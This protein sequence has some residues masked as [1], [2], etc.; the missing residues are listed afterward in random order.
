MSSVDVSRS[1]EGLHLPETI[2]QVHEKI[3]SER[4]LRG[5]ARHYGASFESYSCH[6]LAGR[7]GYQDLL[8][9]LSTEG[10][11]GSSIMSYIERSK[12]ILRP[13][14]IKFMQDNEVHFQP[15]VTEADKK[16]SKEFDW[17]MF[18]SHETSYLL[19]D[20]FDGS[21]IETPALMHLR[22]VAELFYPVVDYSPEVAKSADEL[23]EA[24]VCY[25]MATS[26]YFTFASPVFFNAGHKLPNLC[27]CFL[28]SAEDS[29]TGIMGAMYKAALV[30]KATGGV[31][32]NISSLRHSRI[33]HNGMSRGVMPML[34]VYDRLIRYVDQSG[35]RNGASTVFI[36]AH[37]IDLMAVIRSTLKNADS[38]NRLDALNTAI[39]FPDLFWERLK[40]DGQWTLFC[41]AIFPGLNESYGATYR[42][43]YLK[44]ETMPLDARDA[45][46]RV[47]LTA[48]EVC[49]TLADSQIMS[50]MPYVLHKDSINSCSNQ[51]NLKSPNPLHHRIIQSSNLCLEIMEQTDNEEVACC[52][53]GQLSLKAFVTKDG[54]SEFDFN[55]F[56][57]VVRAKVKFLDRVIDRNRYVFPEAKTSNMRHRP[58]GLGVSGYADMLDILRIPYESDEASVLNRKI[59]A[60]MYFNA[61][62]SSLELAIRDGPYSTFQGSPLSEGKFAFDLWK[63][64]RAGLAPTAVEP[65]PV[66]PSEWGQQ[67]LMVEGVDTAYPATWDYLRMLVVKYGVRN[68]QMLAIMPSASTSRLMGNTENTE[69]H[70]SNIYLRNF[71]RASAVI[72]NPQLFKELDGELGL[73]SRDVAEFMISQGGSV[74]R[75]PEFLVATA[76]DDAEREKVLSKSA[77]LASLCLRYKTMFE[78]KQLKILDQVAARHRYIC[79]GISHNVYLEKPTRAML[80]TLHMATHISGLKTGIYYL[81]EPAPSA[82][83]EYA[84][85]SQ[86]VLTFLSGKVMPIMT[87]HHEPFPAERQATPE[88]RVTA[89]RQDGDLFSPKLAPP[90]RRVEEIEDD[91]HAAFT[92]LLARDDIELVTPEVAA[93]QAAAAEAEGPACVRAPGC[94]GCGS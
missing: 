94:V 77:E 79:Q 14:I 7:L 13:E 67:S 55:L 31:G 5:A 74:A 93:S 38:A 11:S 73:W 57:H 40:T 15:C 26:Q 60:C 47:H 34:Q 2:E 89:P 6:L 19:R 29:L 75:L 9:S 87:T 30:S 32:L 36:Q 59:F 62:T 42:E 66:D 61:M 71:M 65:T 53:L 84:R 10:R 80:R 18:M 35:K 8:N 56:A 43:L 23:G 90:P 63:A 68:S 82:A 70:Q 24:L 17:L 28:M 41:P 88:L 83:P 33:G 69:A 54:K 85:T 4:G 20:K 21:I 44:Y 37:H 12:Q 81:R 72:I 39:V 46:Y 25:E 22:V 78:I 45:P 50:G 49:D 52:N 3:V 48:R 58:I 51:V 76:A 16:F 92:V 91:G 1:V 86:R 27:S 64:R